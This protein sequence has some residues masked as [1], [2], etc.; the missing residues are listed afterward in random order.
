MMKKTLFGTK[1]KALLRETM[2][3]GQEELQKVLILTL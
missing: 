3:Q 1:M 2:G